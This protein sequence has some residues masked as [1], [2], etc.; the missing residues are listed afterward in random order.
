MK[1][2]IILFNIETESKCQHCICTLYLCGQVYT[3]WL[4]VL[5]KKRVSYVKELVFLVLSPLG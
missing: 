1:N 2:I 5:L 4:F 3:P